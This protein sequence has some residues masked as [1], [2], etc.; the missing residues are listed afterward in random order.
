MAEAVIQVHGTA[1][2]DGKAL[3][4]TVF[5]HEPGYIFAEFNIHNYLPDGQVSKSQETLYLK[6]KYPYTPKLFLF[7]T[8]NI[9]QSIR[10]FYNRIE[11]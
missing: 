1:A 5:N 6:H 7:L 11:T 4:Y 2:G 10:A 3:G 9:L 8:E